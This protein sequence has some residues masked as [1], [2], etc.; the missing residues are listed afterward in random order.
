MKPV[1]SCPSSNAISRRWAAIVGSC[2]ALLFSVVALAQDTTPAADPSDAAA[3]GPDSGRPRIGLVLSGGG[4]RGAAHVGVLKA[5]EDIRVPVDAIVGTSM[6]AVVGGLYA[7]G[8]SAADIEKLISSI[9]WQDAFRDRPSRKD[10]AFRRKQ[11]DRDFPVRLPLGLKSGKLLYPRGL[12]QGQ[13]LNQMLRLQT[14][15]VSQV[16]SFDDLP[17]AFRAVAADIETGAT[18]VLDHGDLA[19]A[20]RASMSAP[21]VFEPVEVDKRVLV[22]GGLAENLPAEIAR[23]MHVDVLIVSDVS[24]PL[25]KRDTLMSPLDVSNQMVA[26]LIQR[27]TKR[28][29]ATL[30]ERDVVIEPLLGGMTS[31]DF[32]NVDEA[33]SS[34]EVAAQTVATRLAELSVSGDQYAQ[35][36]ARRS[37]RERPGPQIDFVRSDA[38]SKRYARII[39]AAMEPL[40]GKPLDSSTL[41][42]RITELYGLDL[43]ETVDYRLVRDDDRD[44]LEVSA[45]RKSWGPNYVRF[46]LNLQDDFEGNSSYNAASRFII[47]EVNRLGAEWVTDLQVGENPLFRTEFYQPIT[48]SPR[49]FIAPQL[50]FEVRNVQ[51]LNDQEPIAEFRVRSQEAE[52]ALGREFGSWGELRVGVR[53]GFG[54]SRVHIGDPTLPEQDFDTGEFITSFRYDK[55]DNLNFPR[56]GQALEM[57]W[58]AGRTGLGDDE[59]SDILSL[60]ALVARSWGRHTLVLWASGGSTVH[61]DAA[62]PSVQDFFTLG[63]FLNLSGLTADSVAGPHFAIARALYYRQIGRGDRPGLLNVPVYAGVSMEIG[64]AWEQRSQASFDNTRKDGSLFLGLDTFLGPLYLAVGYDSEGETAFYLFMGRPF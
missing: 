12:I 51:L 5:L 10:L 49:Y 57:Q 53:R 1:Q 30:T 41:E 11:D 27:E 18:V 2:A 44:G 7:S 47:T 33:I 22:D 64:N 25:Q 39:D 38:R 24:F 63:G 3:A 35:Y 16:E 40:I 15:P 60:D 43:F 55:L 29:R 46:S 13:K 61:S 52:L 14:L 45:R 58:T 8:M 26:I 9:D 6:G 48:Y 54:Q 59:S 21:G 56:S 36:L 4:A 23:A 20:M 62:T 42:R 32:R 17:I 37:V 34:G 28:Q 31:F 50:L 19:T